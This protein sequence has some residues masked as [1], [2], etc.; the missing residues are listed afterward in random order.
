M[1]TFH[2]YFFFQLATGISFIL[3]LLIETQLSSLC[4]YFLIRIVL[5]A[6]IGFIYLSSIIG[7]LQANNLSSAFICIFTIATVISIT[8]TKIS[9]E[10][11][12]ASLT[13]VYSLIALHLSNSKW[14]F[15]N[16][17]L[18]NNQNNFE[19]SALNLTKKRPLIY[20]AGAKLMTIFCYFLPFACI[21]SRATLNNTS[22]DEIFTD[23]IVLFLTRLALG[24]ITILLVR[25]NVNYFTI[26]CLMPFAILLAFILLIPLLD[27]RR[28]FEYTLKFRIIVT[29]YVAFSLIVDVIGHRI[30]FLANNDL[31]SIPK[32]ISLTFANFIEHLIDVLFVVVYL[33]DLLSAKL[34]ITSLVIIS[35]TLFFHMLTTSCEQNNRITRKKEIL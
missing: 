8:R 3:C 26:I 7:H 24:T 16:T 2:Y 28:L 34:I 1:Q 4:D 19:F 35:L 10:T 31:G 29:L 18:N 13:L 25:H 15:P 33:N 5:A 11:S 12:S 32:M 23:L 21:I 22:T 9:T 27:L 30:A 14:L 20:L 17:Q 6:L